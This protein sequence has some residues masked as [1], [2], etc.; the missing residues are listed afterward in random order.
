MRAKKNLWNEKRAMNFTWESFGALSALVG[1]VAALNLFVTKAVLQSE[2][3]KF[4]RPIGECLLL[5]Q[6]IDARLKYLDQTS[7]R[8][9]RGAREDHEAD[10]ARLDALESGGE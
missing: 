3:K 9:R 8:N 10:Q 5:H 2:L 4:A 7:G 1:G 6:V